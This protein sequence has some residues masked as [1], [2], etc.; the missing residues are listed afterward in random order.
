M[1]ID[2]DATKNNTTEEVATITTATRKRCYPSGK[3]LFCNFGDHFADDEWLNNGNLFP[4]L[5][6]NYSQKEVEIKANRIKKQVEKPPKKSAPQKMYNVDKFSEIE[7][8]KKNL[9]LK[10]LLMQRKKKQKNM[11]AMLKCHNEARTKKNVCK[12]SVN[13]FLDGKKSVKPL[14]RTMIKLQ[15]HKGTKEYTKEEKDLAKQMFYYSASGYS[16]MRKAGLNL[17]SESSVRNWISETEIR[18][19]FCEEIFYKI[20]ENLS[21]LPSSQTVCCLKFDEMSIKKFEEYSRKYDLIER[22]IDLGPLRRRNEPAEHVLLF[23]LDSINA[24]NPWWQ[25]VAYFLV[26][27]SSTHKE[28]VQLTEICLQK[29]KSIGANVQIITCHQGGANRKAYSY[30]KISSHEPFLSL[31]N[32]TYFASFDWP[33]LIKR[34]I[35][36]LRSHKYIYVN[37][38][39]IMSFYDLFA[40]WQFDRKLNTSN[41]LGHITCTHFYQNNFE[42]MNVKRAF[43]MLSARFAA[44]ILT[45]GQSNVL[46][47]NSWKASADFVCK[48]NKV[49]DAMNIYHLNNWIGEKEPLS[50]ANTMAEEL[51]TSFIEWCSK[52]STSFNKMSKPPCFG[53]MITT[54]QAILSTYRSIKQHNPE[55]K[56]ATA[57]CNQDS[58]EHTFG[59]IRGRG[60][61]NRNPTARM[62]RLT[63]RHILSSGNIYGSDRGNVICQ[64]TSSLTDDT[65]IVRGEMKINNIPLQEELTFEMDPMDNDD[66]DNIIVTAFEEITRY[67]EQNSDNLMNMTEEE[68]FNSTYE[69][70]A[71]AYFAGYM[72]ATVTRIQNATA[73]VKQI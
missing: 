13:E 68:N 64:E 47:S 43:Q 49:I 54:V 27:K 37:G 4:L 5:L 34:L 57:L 56:L 70:N 33:H 53:G 7:K 9:R 66:Y 55:F 32:E 48:M 29:L 10:K 15:L 62:V 46:K 61:F 21:K 1:E 50:N 58:V 35:S 22:L 38:E 6:D 24:E 39:I 42:T 51:L 23:C 8:L 52:W 71:I 11:T 69:R 63:L 14:A 72:L 73:A 65:S 19:G 16:R 44:A 2:T 36:Q 28:I 40:T 12:H 60:G 26:G 20:Q 30:W 31:N 17:P 67:S 25:I 59:K 18:P 45:A 3:E 41:L